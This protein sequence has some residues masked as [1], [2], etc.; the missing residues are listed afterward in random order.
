MI[1]ISIMRAAHDVSLAAIDLNLLVVLDALLTERHVTR[2]AQR[3][4][5]TQPAASHALARLRALLGDPL[6][7]RGPRGALVATPRAEA[8]APALRRALD[9][10]GQALRGQPAFDPGTTRRTFRI[11]AGDYAELALLP[12]LMARLAREAPA[13]DLWV[14]PLSSDTAPALAGALAG[15]EIDLSIGVWS[16]SDWPAGFYQKRLFDEDFQVVLRAG[17]PAAAQRLTLP[18]FCE[19][20]HLLIA[21]GG[22]PGSF[23]DDALA[24][25]GRR[26][27]VAIRVPHFLVAPH[28]ITTTD[29]VVTLATRIAR[30]YAEPLGLVLVPPPLEVPTFTLSMAWHERTH[31]DPAHRWF[32]EVT[33]A[34][35]S[36]VAR[37]R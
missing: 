13:I 34:V 17:H 30:I 11:G 5:V 22:T 16:P 4:G 15:G 36:S 1:F 7:V 35:S 24:R 26:R 33:L 18:R 25:V 2:A 29:L 12:P 31:H 3:I 19:L 6:L 32:R 28:V 14:V 10:V 20:S 21:P 23:V 37:S 8:I 27:H 9:D